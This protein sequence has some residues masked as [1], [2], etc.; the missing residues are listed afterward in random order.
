MVLGLLDIALIAVSAVFFVLTGA[1]FV[2][3]QRSKRL[4]SVKKSVR[5]FTIDGSSVDAP[6]TVPQ[7]AGGIM[8]SPPPRHS[9]PS[10]QPRAQPVSPPIPLTPFS[11]AMELISHSSSTPSPRILSYKMP[12]LSTSAESLD[13]YP[14]R[15]IDS[16]NFSHYS[17]P[18]NSHTCLGSG[19]S[20]LPT[21]TASA[22]RFIH[23]SSTNTVEAFTCL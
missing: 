18:Q 1:M 17:T 12:P 4:A 19:S 15:A 22:K 14:T 3:W 9:Q 7:E 11:Q 6:P 10:Q 8:Q 21:L 13:E 23:P 2:L 16:P 20:R 5:A